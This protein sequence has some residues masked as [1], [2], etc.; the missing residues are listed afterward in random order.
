VTFLALVMGAWMAVVQPEA[1]PVPTPFERTLEAIDAKAE[2]VQDLT[3]DFEQQ[4][5][6]PLLKK[7]LVSKGT[8]RVKGA[9]TRWDTEKPQQTVMTIDAAEL[10]IYYPEQKTVEVYPVAAG[11]SRLAASPLPRLEVIREHF[12]VEEVAAKEIDAGAKAGEVGMRLVP[13]EEGLREHVAQ[14]R[15]LVDGGGVG[16]KVEITD[17]DGEVT[18]MV[19]TNVRMNTGLKDEA[20]VLKVPA[21][22]KESRPLS[23]GPEERK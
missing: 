21:G 9:R 17:A 8:V 4:K 11:M 5:K 20:L 19:F 7:P 2:A 15:V 18:T 6:T 3:A 10:R 23:G 14:V 22:T 1:T 12:V 13:R 16:R